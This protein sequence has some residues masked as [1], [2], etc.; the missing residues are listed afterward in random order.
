MPLRP[1][2]L[3]AENLVLIEGEGE[4]S[5]DDIAMC[6]RFIDT[7]GAHRYRKLLDVRR[8]TTRVRPEIAAG[9]ANLVRSREALGAGGAFAVVLGDDASL[10]AAAELAAR[11]APA[12]RPFGL[13][14]DM[15]EARRWLDQY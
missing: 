9:L 11:G 10:R 4:I 6:L 7:Q 5:A 1:R 2:F 8:V 13:F 14:N 12:G 3:S 15:E